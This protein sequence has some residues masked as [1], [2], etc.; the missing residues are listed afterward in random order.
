MCISGTILLKPDT[1][2][3]HFLG[4]IQ[5]KRYYLRLSFIVSNPPR[6]I[7]SICNACGCITF[8]FRSGFNPHYFQRS[9]C[10]NYIFPSSCLHNCSFLF[11]S[12]IGSML[13]LR[14]IRSVISSGRNL[15]AISL[16]PISRN[17]NMNF[18]RTTSSPYQ[19]VS[20]STLY[21]LRINPDTLYTIPYQTPFAGYGYI[22]P[23]I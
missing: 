3:K 8:L 16:K 1:A 15:P 5:F 18:T 22:Y 7:V 11:I 14:H 19:C 2:C 21:L 10:T 23:D 20:D 6:K 17:R 4:F 9:F 13:S 12:D